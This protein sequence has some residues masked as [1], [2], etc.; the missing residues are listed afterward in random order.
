MSCFDMDHRTKK[1]NAKMNKRL[2][3]VIPHYNNH[4][5]LLESIESIDEPIAVDLVVVDDGS[6][7]KPKLIQIQK[8]LKKGLVKLICLAENK[9]ITHALNTALDFAKKNNYKY[10]A[11]LDAGDICY[12]NKFSKQISFLQKNNEIQL[13]GT[14]ARVIKANGD[15]LYNLKHPSLDKVI[16]KKM[17]LN[18]MFVHPT[19]MF[20]SVILEK[21]KEYPVNYP[22][23][24]QDYAF[25]FEVLKY[26][27]CA[28]IPEILL[29]YVVNEN[30][31]SKIRR[32]EQVLNRIKILLS[33]FR[34]GFYPIYGLTRNIII[35]FI[36][37]F[38]LNSI[39]KTFW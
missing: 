1:N 27:K 16:R 12:K 22:N 35:F 37:L 21:V 34:F 28:N 14:W 36:P 3:V 25:L 17:Y 33:N 18:S 9:G 39:K 24:A 32:K 7:V 19:I 2:I 10:I 38:V 29:D 5:D 23:S 30:S 13:V 11:R 20:K 31:I 6:D 15:F 8:K 26:Y 4:K